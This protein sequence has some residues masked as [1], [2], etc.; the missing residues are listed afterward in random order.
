ML[1]FREKVVLLTE[2]PEPRSTASRRSIRRRRSTSSRTSRPSATGSA[3]PATAWRCTC[4]KG[5]TTSS[6]SPA[7]AANASARRAGASCASAAPN[8]TTACKKALDFLPTAI[9]RR[10][11]LET[12]LEKNPQHRLARPYPSR[13]SGAGGRSGISR[14]GFRTRIH[15]AYVKAVTPV[16]GGMRARGQICPPSIRRVFPPDGFPL[17][18]PAERP[19]FF[20]RVRDRPFARRSPLPARTVAARSA[21]RSAAHRATFGVACGSKHLRRELEPRP[22]IVTSARLSYEHQATTLPSSQRFRTTRTTK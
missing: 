4:S 15:A 18:C 10:D 1:K 13:W 9:A 12:W 3:S 7:S 19:G 14:R 2:G 21:T 11:R 17:N 20:L 6:A 22:Q 8:R 16:T 5:P